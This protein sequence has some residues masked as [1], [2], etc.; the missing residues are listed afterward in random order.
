[1]SVAG[2]ALALCA[3]LLATSAG[4]ADVQR[5]VVHATFVDM[6][7][8]RVSALVQQDGARHEVPLVDDGSDPADAAG[9]RVWTGSVE[10]APAQYLPVSLSVQADDVSREVWTGT[11]HAG[12]EARVDLALE[13]A[14]G[15]DGALSGRRR[16][17][18]APGA[19][20]HA[21]EAMP[22]LAV[23]GWALVLLAFAAATLRGRPPAASPGEPR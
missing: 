14:R 3:A 4:A 12:L 19:M 10:G 1:V 11:V 22:F 18:A 17:T 9:D 21:A 2:C 13:V 5:V 20:A 16:A 23:A 6:V 15:P 7:P 8:Q